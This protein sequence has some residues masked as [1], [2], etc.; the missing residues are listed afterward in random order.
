MKEMGEVTKDVLR[1]LQRSIHETAKSKGWH[2]DTK[3]NDP[4]QVLAWLALV[5]SEIGECVESVR[6]GEHTTYVGVGGKPEGLPSE[7]ADIVIR[8]FD[9]AGALDIDMAEAI[10]KKTHYNETRSYKHGGKLV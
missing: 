3:P 1:A 5:T 6:K 4:V 8:V 10:A 2:E 7:L 9:I